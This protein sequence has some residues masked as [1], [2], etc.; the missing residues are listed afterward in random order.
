M[1]LLTASEYCFSRLDSRIESGNGCGERPSYFETMENERHQLSPGSTVFRSNREDC[2]LIS[3]CL[4][5]DTEAYGILVDRYQTPLFNTALRMTSDHELARDITQNAFVKAYEKLASY[6][7]EHKFFSWLYRI[8]VN[9]ALNVLRQNRFE[10]E[11][12]ESVEDG[13]NSPEDEYWEREQNRV[14]DSAIRELSHDHRLVIVMRHFN[15]MSYEQMAE[16]LNIPAKTVKSR[17]YSARQNLAAI[18]EQKGLRTR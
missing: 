16:I 11:I 18:L 17:L 8:L 9:D 3:Q 7:P 4:K 12:P 15:D 10:T 1:C 13:R 2:D 14:I 6:R 5:G